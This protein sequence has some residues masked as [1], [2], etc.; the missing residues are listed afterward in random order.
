RE[1]VIINGFYKDTPVT[2]CSTGIGGPSASIAVEELISSGAHTFIRVGTSGALKLSVNPG[3]L[4]I[5]QAAVRDEGTANQYFPKEFP[6]RASLDIIKAL[7]NASENYTH[8]IGLVHSKDAFYT[9]LEPENAFFREIEEQKLI[10]Y[11]KAGVL[12]SEMEVA[13]ILAVANIRKIRAGA[14]L[15]VIE[16]PMLK[17]M[18]IHRP[19]EHSI[20]EMIKISLEALHSLYKKDQEGNL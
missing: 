8:H 16:A 11:S 13:A 14:I 4:V 18:N 20:D 5:A 17:R 15:Q 9:E 3:D 10:H 2:I 6:V 19:L 7:R 1:Y 12:C